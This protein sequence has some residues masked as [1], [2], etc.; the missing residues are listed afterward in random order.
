MDSVP[1]HHRYGP[2]TLSSSGLPPAPEPGSSLEL[3]EDGDGDPPS[4]RPVPR[5]IS[6]PTSGSFT[7]ALTNREDPASRSTSPGLGDEFGPGLG[8]IVGVGIAILSVM[9]P[10]TSVILDRE[11]APSGSLLPTLPASTVGHESLQPPSNAGTWL[12]ESPR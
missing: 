9:V 2:A 4:P 11:H 5:L 8:W 12:G 1:S 7:G 3:I 6:P 10:L